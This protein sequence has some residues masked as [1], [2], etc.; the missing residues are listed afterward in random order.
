M[1]GYVT[2]KGCGFVW[3]TENDMPLI[4]IEDITGNSFTAY[5]KFDNFGSEDE[6]KLDIVLSGG[7]WKIDSISYDGMSF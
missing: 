5:A 6:M 4:E 1:Y 3:I 2:A 7:L